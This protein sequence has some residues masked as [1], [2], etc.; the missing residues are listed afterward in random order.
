MLKD[1]VDLSINKLIEVKRVFSS[2][3]YTEDYK[4]GFLS[5]EHLTEGVFNPYAAGG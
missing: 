5:H 4:A 1:H 3:G 2:G